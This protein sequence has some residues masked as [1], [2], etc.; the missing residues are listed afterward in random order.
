MKLS[1][2]LLTGVWVLMV[3]GWIAVAVHYIV[4]FW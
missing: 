4:K 3:L 1:M 2:V